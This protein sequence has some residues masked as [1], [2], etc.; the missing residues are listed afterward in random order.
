MQ[1]LINFLVKGIAQHFAKRPV[2]YV[3][4]NKPIAVK[5]MQTLSLDCSVK[6]V[7][8][9]FKTDYFPD[10][11]PEGEVMVSRKIMDLDPTADQFSQL[12]EDLEIIGPDRIAVFNPKIKEIP[13]N[14]YFFGP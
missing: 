7:Q 9:C 5:Q 13:D 8:M 6:M 4:L 12:M 2:S 11:G 14:K 1:K 3:G 10:K